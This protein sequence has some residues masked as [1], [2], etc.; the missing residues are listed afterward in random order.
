[1][2][3][4]FIRDRVLRRL[5]LGLYKGQWYEREQRDLTRTR[6]GVFA[7]DFEWR[8]GRQADLDALAATLKERRL[9][10]DPQASSENRMVL[11]GGSQV[12]T[13]FHGGYFVDPRHLPVRAELVTD[14]D[15][16]GRGK[17]RLHVR[18]TLGIARRDIALGDR[19]EIAAEA[20]REVV[21][22]YLEVSSGAALA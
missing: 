12:R 6:G 4:A 5:S 17:L 19:Y 22:D 2:Q 13:R 15:G 18:D 7:F 8:L 21:D 16:D 20:I 9:V 3:F 14:S 10:V 11:C 1:M